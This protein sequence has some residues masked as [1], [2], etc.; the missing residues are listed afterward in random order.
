MLS[1]LM[2]LF[3]T[4]TRVCKKSKLA[5]DFL[6]KISGLANN[7]NGALTVVK[8]S[9]R[10]CEGQLLPRAGIFDAAYIF[11]NAQHCLLARVKKVK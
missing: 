1:P 11:Q 3:A 4:Q 6:K 7:H 2:I 8:V 5:A 10:K 9:L